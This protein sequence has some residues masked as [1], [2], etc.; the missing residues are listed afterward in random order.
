MNHAENRFDVSFPMPFIICVE[1]TGWWSGTDG[2]AYHQPFR[3][4]MDRPHCAEDYR[5]L[6]DLGRQLS[7]KI[8][9]GFTACEWD[10]A[11]ILKKVPT[12]TWMGKDWKPPELDEA[13]R[14]KACEILTRKPGH[15]EI[16]L[17]GTG[18]EYWIDGRMHRTEFHDEQCRMRNP[19]DIR[20]HLAAFFDI[21]HQNRLP[22]DI[23]AFIPP[24]LKHSFGNGDDG[25]QKIVNE[26]SIRYVPTVFEKAA[27]LGPADRTPPEKYG[28]YCENHVLLVERGICETDWHVVAAKPVFRFD[29]PVLAL[30]W[31]NMLARDPADNFAIVSRWAEYLK[32][33]AADNGMIPAKDFASCAAQFIFWKTA[34]V[35]PFG[36]GFVADLSLPNS[37]FTE[38]SG[39][40]CHIR[41]TPSDRGK[42]LFT[43]AD[44]LHIIHE[45]G[46]T[47]YELKVEPGCRNFFIQPGARK[48]QS[49]PDPTRGSSFSTLK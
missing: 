41:V 5:A 40:T 6:E 8:L 9:A 3:T 24:G 37:Q 47:L 22:T 32:K 25:F 4:G 43:G 7:M 45:P 15:I 21:L 26:F 1:D 46:S 16:A 38:F 13:E 34:S 2:S 27:R 10:R 28:L 33:G 39:D 31:A 49:P 18:H 36:K 42:S 35:K 30:H 19:S 23:R 44:V 12:A 14:D 20:Q 48:D 11:G 29:R 17:H